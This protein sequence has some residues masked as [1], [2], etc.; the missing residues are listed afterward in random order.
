LQGRS[1]GRA[2]GVAGRDIA[3]EGD[4][5]HRIGTAAESG[6]VLVAIKRTTVG[7]FNRA[8]AMRVFGVTRA[9]NWIPAFAGMTSER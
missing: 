4:D 2:D 7:G 6:L 9:R 5:N 8:K 1:A 3:V